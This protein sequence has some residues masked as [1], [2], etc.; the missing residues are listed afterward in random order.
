MAGAAEDKH[1][2]LDNIQL[3][4]KHIAYY[5]QLFK[6]QNTFMHNYFRAHKQL[7]GFWLKMHLSRDMWSHPRRSKFLHET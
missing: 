5:Y 3:K 6:C 1:D 7:A 2:C 4:E